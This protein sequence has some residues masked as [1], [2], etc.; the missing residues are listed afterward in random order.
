MAAAIECDGVGL[1]LVTILVVTAALVAIGTWAVE[2][3]D[4]RSA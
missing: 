2:R 4:I 3:R 1:G